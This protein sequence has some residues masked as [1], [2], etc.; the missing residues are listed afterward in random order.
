MIL[1][2][3]II[4]LAWCTTFIQATPVTIPISPAIQQPNNLIAPSLNESLNGLEVT[5]NGTAYGKNLDAASC[6]DLI[7]YQLRTLKGA[8]TFAPRGTPDGQR[9]SY[10]TPWRW[11]SGECLITSTPSIFVGEQKEGCVLLALPFECSTPE[12]PKREKRDSQKSPRATKA[13]P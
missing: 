5:C 4:S 11:V 9:A 6:Y 2:S 13:V 10:P 12:T 1:S 7:R 8:G 3:I